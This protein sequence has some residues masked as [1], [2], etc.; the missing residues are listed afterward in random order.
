MMLERELDD[1]CVAGLEIN[2]FRME[3]KT[4]R[5]LFQKIKLIKYLVCV[6]VLKDLYNS[7]VMK[8]K[9]MEKES[10]QEKMCRKT[11]II[12]IVRRIM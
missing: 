8:T 4:W 1:N 12:Y 10:L 9:Q 11:E 6:D 7:L 2:H 3:Q 5:D